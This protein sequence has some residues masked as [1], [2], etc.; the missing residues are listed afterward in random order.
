MKDAVDENFNSRQ[1]YLDI[2]RIIACFMVIMIHINFCNPAISI[3]ILTLLV[4]LVSFILI[5]ILHKIP[6]LNKILV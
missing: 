1:Y 2:L 4:F 3:L 5:F 6:I